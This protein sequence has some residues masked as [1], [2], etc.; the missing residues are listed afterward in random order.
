[1]AYNMPIPIGTDPWGTLLNDS[2][3][4]LHRMLETSAV[5]HGAIAWTF[6]NVSDSGSSTITTGTPFMSKVWVREPAT[7]STLYIS[8]TTS[9]VSLTAGQ[10]FAGVYNAAGTRLAVTA[11]QTT[12]WG[13]TTGLQTMALTVPVAV[14]PGAYYITLLANGTTSPN[15]ARGAVAGSGASTV[16]FG[17]TAA[18]ARYSTGPAAQ[19]SLPASITM[20]SRTLSAISMWSAVA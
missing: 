8:I 10:N 4:E 20:A 3:Y 1:M 5:D 12:A 15:L 11:D 19:T 16:N 9:G 18:T 2:M 17:L 7:L 6:D 14:T 13:T